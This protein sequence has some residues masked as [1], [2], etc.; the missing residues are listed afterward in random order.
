MRE[1]AG[2]SSQRAQERT[3]RQALFQQ[4][5]GDAVQE[6]VTIPE[7]ELPAPT[8]ECGREEQIQVSLRDGITL[9]TQVLLPS[10][11]GPWPVILVRSPYPGMAPLLNALGKVWARQGYAFVGQACR[12][13]GGS[14]GTW[15]PWEN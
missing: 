9:A 6:L 4:N 2:R 15:I 5:A 14:Q 13:T 7:K 11:I 10:G 1:S 3:Q 12:G 8:A